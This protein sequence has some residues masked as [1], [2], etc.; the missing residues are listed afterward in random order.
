MSVLIAIVTA[1]C[2]LP[3]PRFPYELA[4]HGFDAAKAR[5]LRTIVPASHQPPPLCNAGWLAFK[6]LLQPAGSEPSWLG[7]RI[8][9]RS[10]RGPTAWHQAR[11]APR[12]IMHFAGLAPHRRSHL[13]STLDLTNS[14][15]RYTTRLELP[16]LQP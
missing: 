5:C 12:P 10:R 11:E 2:S 6:S 14:P 7:L 9:C 3:T 16:L 4:G 1:R 13:T 15:R 8:T